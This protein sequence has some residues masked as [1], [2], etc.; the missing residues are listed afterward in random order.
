MVNQRLTKDPN[1]RD[2][3]PAVE[4]EQTTVL[5]DRIGVR[6][7]RNIIAHH[8]CPEQGVA[9][10][11]PSPVA[12]GRR[13]G[14]GLL[15]KEMKQIADDAPGLAHHA[16]DAVMSIHALEE[17]SAQ[18]LLP[19]V[20][21]FGKSRQRMIERPDLGDAG[22]SR[23]RRPSGEFLR[24]IADPDADQAPDRF[25]DQ[26][27]GLEI[28]I[29]RRHG[30]ERLP[31]QRDI[32]QIGKGEEARPEPILNV[33]IIVGDVVGES[34][35]LSLGTCEG[36]EF[37]RL[38]GLIIA[39]GGRQ[40][41]RILPGPQERTIMLDDPLKGLPGEVQSVES[42]IFVLKARQD[43]Q[44]LGVVIKPAIRG[45]DRIEGVFSGMA[46]G[47]MAD[48]VGEGERF[49]E[50]LVQPEG[51]GGR[52]GDLGD[53][54]GMSEAGPVVIAFMGDED[55]GLLLEAT[56]RVGVND[57]V[58]VALKIGPGTTWGFGMEAPAGCVG[59]ARIGRPAPRSMTIAHDQPF[60]RRNDPLSQDCVSS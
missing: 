43:P 38:E 37:K 31:R 5:F 22:G 60:F 49:S 8:P 23:P 25:S 58:P 44:G 24:E 54:K 4:I 21:L 47:R 18:G 45:H 52:A 10:A 57:P 11:E 34:G 40:T 33:V 55:L 42:G 19:R 48:I 27:R 56:E 7:S 2:S 39:K 36:M 3:V 15:K 32:H 51:A 14:F 46:E 29:I 59:I 17:E 1:P 16:I 9:L 50:I 26:A 53:L 30:D 13:Q 35:D 28:G 20:D 41:R 12:P 6:H